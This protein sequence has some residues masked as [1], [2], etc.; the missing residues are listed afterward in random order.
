MLFF[1]RS[2]YG[3]FPHSQYASGITN[4]TAI[5]SHVDH[6]PL[7]LRQ[8]CTIAIIQNKGSMR[9]GIILTPITLFSLRRGTA[10]NHLVA[11]AMRAT[12][13]NQYH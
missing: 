13:W 5:D 12:Y 10:F 7:H 3:V 9:T 2:E 8:I 6:L 1:Q 11:I 4:T